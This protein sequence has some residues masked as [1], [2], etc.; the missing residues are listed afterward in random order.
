MIHQHLRQTSPGCHVQRLRD[1]LDVFVFGHSSSLFYNRVAPRYEL[2]SS[3]E[4]HFGVGITLAL[5]RLRTID[6]SCTRRPCVAPPMSYGVGLT[7]GAVGVREW[8]P[9]IYRANLERNSRYLSAA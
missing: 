8:T 6:Y 9:V 7:I 3:P 5:L 1:L 4:A 2:R